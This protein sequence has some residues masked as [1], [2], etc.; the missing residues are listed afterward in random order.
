[1]NLALFTSSRGDYVGV[2]RAR[3]ID[4]PGARFFVSAAIAVVVV[5]SVL[6]FVLEAM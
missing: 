1:M 2:R 4:E 5:V 3:L 6:T